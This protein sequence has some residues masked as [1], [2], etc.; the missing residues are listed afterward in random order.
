MFTNGRE[1]IAFSLSGMLPLKAV[2]PEAFRPPHVAPSADA[3]PVV[4]RNDASHVAQGSPD[5]RAAAVSFWLDR[6]FLLAERAPRLLRLAR[7]PL[8]R[9]AYRCSASIRAGTLANAARILGPDSTPAERGAFARK[10]VEHFILFCHDIGRSLRMS[11]DELL[12]R[13]EHIE[14]HPHYD[15]ARRQRRGAIVVTA[16]MGSFE[17]GMAALRRQDAKIHV[18]FRRDTFARFERMRAALR[19][20]LDISEAPVDEGWTVWMRLRDALQNDEVVVLQA[21][22]VMPGQKGHCVPVL[23]AD[24]M[25]PA[26]PVKLAMATGAPIVPVFSIRTPTGGVR[27]CVEPAIEVRGNDID[28]AMRQLAAVVGKYVQA[29]GEQWLMLQPAWCESEDMTNDPSRM[30]RE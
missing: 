16:H 14:G 27:L 19:A 5:I 21:D 10:V 6:L 25:L 15:A 7:V 22:R 9:L 20:R 3:F 12:S 23:G 30:T 2:T 28:Q 18:V 8:A 1:G 17:V 24:M 11:P 13:I 4:A 29:H 26:G